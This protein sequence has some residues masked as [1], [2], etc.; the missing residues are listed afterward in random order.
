[1]TVTEVDD[2]VASAAGGALAASAAATEAN[3]LLFAQ[4]A[5]AALV[6]AAVTEAD[7]TLSAHATTSTG[8]GGGATPEEIWNYVLSN[9]LTAG[10]TLAQALAEAERC[11]GSH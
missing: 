5:V 1:M 9:G 2:S 11:C 6:N 7:D 8:G 10:E 4:A 3:D